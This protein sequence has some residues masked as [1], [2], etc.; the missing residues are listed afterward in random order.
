MPYVCSHISDGLGNRFF[1]VAAALGYAKKHGHTPVFI[2]HWMTDTN[3]IGPKGIRDYFPAIQTIKL[4]PGWTLMQEGEGQVFTYHPMPFVEGNGYLKGYFQSEK[5]FPE[6]GVPR[7]AILAG[8]EERYRNFAFLHVR[9]GDYLLPVCAH[10][11]VDFTAYYRYALSLFAD[12][13]V[14]ILV[15]SDD[16]EWC[17]ATLP[18]R[19]GDLISADRW[20]FLAAD[21]TDYDTLR[22]MTACGRGGICANSTF[23][24]WGAYWNVGRGAAGVHYTMPSVWGRPPVPETRDLYPSWATVLPC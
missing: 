21:A 3:H 4:E 16:I 19:Y 22:A 18:G 24:W 17:R 7:P 9:R 10:H 11:Y 12:S 8:L 23:S 13:G 5:Y 1:Q 20:E 14:R 6:G 15:C 2:D